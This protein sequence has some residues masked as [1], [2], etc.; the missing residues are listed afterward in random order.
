[1]GTYEFRA[2][3]ITQAFDPNGNYAISYPASALRVVP[4]T[5][6]F[7]WDPAADEAD[8]P[9]APGQKAT[10]VYS[11]TNAAPDDK[12]VTPSITNIQ[13]GDAIAVDSVTDATKNQVGG[14]TAKVASLKN[15]GAADKAKNYTV[16]AT[17]AT[18][19]RTWSIA[20]D[21]NVWTSE[22]AVDGWEYA[23]TDA[24]ARHTPTS[25]AKYAK[26]GVEVAYEY[27]RVA[28]GSDAAVSEAWVAWGDGP[29]QAGT[30]K[31]RATLADTENWGP[32]ATTEMDG[33][34]E[35]TRKPLSVEGRRDMESGYLEN[36]VPLRS[37]VTGLA[38]GDTY[39]G[40]ALA[41]TGYEDESCTAMHLDGNIRPTWDRGT[42]H[43]MPQVT[44]ATALN[45]YDISY[46]A[47]TYTITPPTATVSVTGPAAKRY[48]G[49]PS[50]IKSVE[51]SRDGRGYTAAELG[52]TM[53]YSDSPIDSGRMAE[54][55]ALASDAE[56]AAS[57][58]VTSIDD[59]RVTQTDAGTKVVYYFADCKNY[60]PKPQFGSVNLT[61]EKLRM[62]VTAQPATIT[63]GQAASD[64][65]VDV[66]YSGLL[67]GE[68]AE[69]LR[70]AG[71]L[72]GDVSFD[73]NYRRFDDVPAAGSQGELTLTPKGLVADNYD[74]DYV[75]A[76]LTVNPLPVQVAW[77]G[78]SFVFD[79]TEHEVSAR[80][81]NAQNGDDIT[82]GG[83]KNSRATAAGAYRASA[84]TL[85]GDKAG[86]YTIDP[87]SG[88]THDWTIGASQNEIVGIS[89]AGWT[90]DGKTCDGSADGHPKP[91]ATATFGQEAMRF[92][93][94][95]RADF[96]QGT[97]TL[98][99]EPP[100]DAGTKVVYY[101][102]DCKNYLPSLTRA[103]LTEEHLTADKGAYSVDGQIAA[104][105]DLG[106]ELSLEEAP[107]DVYQV[108][109]YKIDLAWRE[110]PNYEVTLSGATLR[111]VPD[112]AL[113]PEAQGFAGTYDGAAHA[114]SVTVPGAAMG[115]Y[116]VWYS[117]E[118]ELTADTYETGTKVAPTATNVSDSCDVHYYVRDLT[119]NHEDASGTTQLTIARRALTLTPA[120]KAIT[121]GEAADLQA[122]QGTY[123]GLVGDDLA[124]GSA[125]K[126]AMGELALETP[127][128]VG[129]DAGSYAINVDLDG[130]AEDARLAN[131]DVRFVPGTL[132][133]GKATATLGW[134][135]TEP[136]SFDNVEHVVSATVQTA[137]A[138]DDVYPGGYENNAKTR[139]GSYTARVTGL[140]GTK[141]KNYEI[142]EATRTRAWVIGKSANA[143]SS[144]RSTGWTYGAYDETSDAPTC[145][146]T[147]GADTAT[148]EWSRSATP[149]VALSAADLDSHGVPRHAGSYY[150][151]ATVPATDDYEGASAVSASPVTVSPAPLTITALDQSIE[152]TATGTG[153]AMREAVEVPAAPTV[154]PTG[155]SGIAQWSEWYEKVSKLFSIAGADAADEN[156]L[157][158][159]VALALESHGTYPV[160]D[161]AITPSF[162]AAAGST[163][164]GD[165]A[166]TCVAG[167]FHVTKGDAVVSAAGWSGTYDGQPHGISLE[168]TDR[169]GT[170]IDSTKFLTTTPI[171]IVD[172]STDDLSGPV[173]KISRA[174]MSIINGS[175]PAAAASAAGT[176]KT[177]LNQR[178][179]VA[180]VVTDQSVAP[181]NAGTTTVHYVVLT[182]PD[183][184]AITVGSRDVTI[185]K[186][187]LVVT[188]RDQRIT[189]GAAPS[190]SAVAGRE[191]VSYATPAGMADDL[192]FAT[193]ATDAFAYGYAKGQDVGGGSFEVWPQGV[194]SDNY[195]IKPAAGTLTVDRREATLD[196]APASGSFAASPA[197]SLAYNGVEQSVVATVSNAH[198]SDDVSVSSYLGNAQTSA[199][200]YQARAVQLSGAKAANYALGSGAGA[201]TLDWQITKAT[202][203]WVDKVS[204]DGW[205]Y[206]DIA[207]APTARARLGAD[208][209]VFEYAAVAGDAFPADVPDGLA[210]TRD[211]PSAAGLY[212]VRATVPD[213]A[214]C[215]ALETA[216]ADYAR[217][218]VSSAQVTVKAE[219]KTSVYGEEPR[220]LTYKA[221]G[222][223]IPGDAALDVALSATT[224]ADPG[225]PQVTS[226]TAVGEYP[227]NVALGQ[228]ST[229]YQI[230][231]QGSTYKILPA[232]LAV[233][234]EGW[235]STYDTE[236]HGV[237]VQTDVPLKEEDRT[238]YYS[239][240]PLTADNIDL[241]IFNGD[242]QQAD[243][244]TPWCTTNALDERI[245]RV[246]VG[247][248]QV[249]YY[250][251]SANYVP[252]P[253][254]GELTV[255]V[256]KAPLII[257]ANDAQITFG[258]EATNA[259]VT[260]E[261][262]VGT[263]SEAN[264]TGEL[265]YDVAYERLG[266]VGEYAI[267]PSGLT[268][269]S[270]DITYETGTLTVSPYTLT[271][272]MLALDPEDS[273]FD[274][275]THA[276]E[277]VLEIPASAG[278][279]AYRLAKGRDFTVSGDASSADF[280]THTLKVEGTGNFTGELER[281]WRVTGEVEQIEKKNGVTVQVSVLA[282][283]TGVKVD[284]LTAQLALSLMTAEQRARVDAGEEA[285]LYL[286]IHQIDELPEEDRAATLA[287]LEELGARAGMYLD[288]RLWLQVGDDPAESISD[289]KG[290]DLTITITAP[291]S[292]VNTDANLVR[293]M[294]GIRTHEGVADV[295]GGPVTEPTISI[296]TGLFSSYTLAIRDEEVG[297][298]G[299]G[300]FEGDRLAPM[301]HVAPTGDPL[302]AAI[303]A[304]AI[305]A[306]V[307][308]L[309]VL[310]GRMGVR[311]GRRKE[312]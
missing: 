80:V 53:Y 143:V 236:R 61:V 161:Y 133:V 221:E 113:A 48:D 196:W 122:G 120:D 241:A 261:G 23:G 94:S 258:D 248:Q 299:D 74:I 159:H 171:Q 1:M 220:E 43:L 307:A 234:A 300:S 62:T 169:Y 311:R 29:S 21:A 256:D 275:K 266:N 72:R 209:V 214:D 44:D 145:E 172:G 111:V 103:K 212:Y 153:A 79:G 83:Y 35:I 235:E 187:D 251:K 202:N 268:S 254:S 304:S 17:E 68:T 310:A 130:V 298:K 89:A 142:D 179:D 92:E 78:D 5:A 30:Y 40:L 191:G 141:A 90:Y 244:S 303:P 189:Y 116:E 198:G 49:T 284:G 11:E 34:F 223:P 168:T 69:G 213:T 208:R 177:R 156:D 289:L 108:G 283:G 59:P 174:T 211:V 271:H 228:N 96:S 98:L 15:T 219:P 77:A 192:R 146:A 3:G 52:I 126:Q 76:P 71:K 227:I 32:I 63:Y 4:L 106:I 50:R 2:T 16:S 138:D 222:G 9:L 123:S 137:V 162:T 255:K 115:T 134:D 140:S 188:A 178:Q 154:P 204:I 263:E 54:Y 274:G 129:D 201:A 199:G 119:G 259:G 88:A 33:T 290:N 272:D 297:G 28:D 127:Y 206:G 66:S 237:D 57:G 270:Y 39:L 239:S 182:N 64:A 131:Y 173:I 250:V 312:L 278:H 67:A 46:A 265:A 45:N 238:V 37:E 231:A 230:Q 252:V 56:R 160:G 293:T 41:Y 6:T 166:V 114:A 51:F 253:L 286:E 136:F 24:S 38:A 185:A 181:T 139:A 73:S 14:Y 12:T 13:N 93:Y 151:R 75:G 294:W 246:E 186:R 267:T 296:K 19:T 26:A 109:S 276:P 277:A 105:D 240:V 279:D 121:Y 226:E 148:Y 245:S 144:V 95:L 207:K 305:I 132:T 232:G 110:S 27:Q 55:K 70:Q 176:L 287:K 104:G 295:V 193:S 269:D 280:G 47:G 101:F 97:G 84:E 155:P 291:D 205:T 184:P 65:K 218:T 229:N 118:H 200:G 20:K 158:S 183:D 170:A 167:E 125:A 22:P 86:N 203:D 225:A 288:M 309:F 257:K 210:W 217:L 102:A 180:T 224:A 264:L 195:N 18:G 282:D 197:N 124:E 58:I 42:Y 100:T 164:A 85:S 112:G 215:A 163:L 249:Y 306:G 190:A 8:Q 150:V 36:L 128:G 152:R 308:A 243:P 260:Y 302:A 273:E 285:M 175:D 292:L 165:Y 281:S 87:S 117:T 7:A 82:L 216:P 247:E 99:S 233:S 157:Y 194:T 262:F 10:F 301:A 149:F 242:A 91:T 135:Y 81:L 107:L 60:L 147:W 31:M 25:T